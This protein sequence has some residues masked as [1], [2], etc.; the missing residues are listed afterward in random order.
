MSNWFLLFIIIYIA[1]LV[2]YHNISSPVFHYF[3]LWHT[4]QIYIKYQLQQLSI[5][6]K[7]LNIFFF[8]AV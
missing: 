8:R 4:H 1:F 2:V 3:V 6:E 5:Y 7:Y